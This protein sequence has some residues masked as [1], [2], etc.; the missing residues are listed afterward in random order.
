MPNKTQ[1]FIV[2]SSPLAFGILLSFLFWQQNWLLVLIYLA[3]ASL[4]VLSGNDKKTELW[5]FIY[6]LVSGF[7]VETIGTQVSGYQSFTQPDILG[8]P[9]WLIISWGYGFVLM[10]RIGLIIATGTPWIKR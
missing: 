8:I 9:Y 7:V 1:Q 2:H 5:V 3:L 6:G 10:K 4:V